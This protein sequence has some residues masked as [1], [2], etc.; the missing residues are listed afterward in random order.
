MNYYNTLIE[1]AE[2]SPATKAEVPKPKGGKKT[3]PVIE[4]E[5]IANHPY[6]Y[7][8][9]DIA[10]ETYAVLHNIPKAIWPKERQTFLSKGHPHLRVS[11]LAKRYGWGIHNNAEGKVALIAVNSL[12]YKKLMKDP[13]TTK[14]KAFRSESA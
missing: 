12:K 3:K 7:T 14:I 13:R 10:F 6:K 5:M 2:G 8:E 4:Y 1:I 11:A 9:E